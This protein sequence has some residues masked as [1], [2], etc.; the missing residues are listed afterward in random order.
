MNIDGVP[1]LDITNVGVVKKLAFELR[2]GAPRPLRAFA[3]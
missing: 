2:A 1:A 3:V